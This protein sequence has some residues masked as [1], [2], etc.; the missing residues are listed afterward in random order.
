[1]RIYY[2]TINIYFLYYEL[3]FYKVNILLLIS[4]NLIKKEDHKKIEK[5]L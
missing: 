5:L 3:I 4:Q 2:S 1:M